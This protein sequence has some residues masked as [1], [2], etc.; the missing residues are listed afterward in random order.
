MQLLTQKATLA[1]SRVGVVF[2]IPPISRIK[3]RKENKM[4]NSI[5]VL[6]HGN[7]HIFFQTYNDKL[8]MV[9]HVKINGTE[10]P[11]FKHNMI[12][13]SYRI[14]RVRVLWAEKVAEGYNAVDWSLLNDSCIEAIYD[15][16]IGK[17]LEM[18]GV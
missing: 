4:L 8:V 1:L 13:Y 3:K 7:K 9:F 14:D 2:T 11:S 6:K 12:I 15:K 5:K 18:K 10:L 16:F 17:R